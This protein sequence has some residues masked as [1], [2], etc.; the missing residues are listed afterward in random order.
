MM[1]AISSAVPS[2][3]M[4]VGML[5]P[6]SGLAS[7]AFCNNGVRIEPGATVRFRKWSKGNERRRRTG[8][9]KSSRR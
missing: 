9:F 4:A 1:E 6:S 8:D 7:R 2:L 5:E 3:L